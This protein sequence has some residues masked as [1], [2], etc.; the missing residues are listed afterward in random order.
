MEPG[1]MAVFFVCEA[2]VFDYIN[3]GDPTIFERE[4]LENLAKDGEMYTYKHNGFWL[5]MDTLRDKNRLNELIENK[6]APWIKW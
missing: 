4:P 6:T 3:H 5:P 2:K 1:L